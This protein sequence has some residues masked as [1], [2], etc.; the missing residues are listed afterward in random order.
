MT[1][2]EGNFHPRIPYQIRQQAGPWIERLTRSL[3]QPSFRVRRTEYAGTVDCSREDLEATLQ[4]EG[5]SW[6]PF[7]LYHRTSTG[8]RSDGS[9]VYRPS[10]RS[11][12]QIH[13][14][15]FDQPNDTVDVYAH[16]EYNQVRHPIKHVRQVGVDRSEGAARMRRWLNARGLDHD[17]E[18]RLTQTVTHLLEKASERYSSG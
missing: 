13:V 6:A 14:I 11:H 5:F 17:H 12:R 4:R 9:W 16:T 10:L 2:S 3:G 1:D 7:S 8:I 18:S 15:L